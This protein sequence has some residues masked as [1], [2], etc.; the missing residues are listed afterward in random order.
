MRNF[1]NRNKMFLV[2]ALKFLL[3][4]SLFAPLIVSVN[5]L[6]PF[7]FPKAIFFEAL[8]QMAGLVFVALLVVDKNFFPRKNI[9][10]YGLLGWSLTMILSTIFSVDPSLA[11][12][13]KA[14][15]MDGLFWYL[16]LFLFFVMAS[17]V[18]ERDWLRFLSINS[19]AGLITGLYALASKFLP[20]AI[21]FG[22]QIRLAGTFGNPAFLGTYFLAL[23]FLNGILFL[24]YSGFKVAEK[25]DYQGNSRFLFLGAAIFSLILVILSGTR[26]AWIGVASGLVLF[27]GLV[28]IF[29]RGKYFRLGLSVLL[30]LIIIF[31]SLRFLPQVW[32]KISPFFASR[33]Y[34]LWEIPTP[35]LIVWG[36]G[37]NA[38]LEKPILGWGLEN[39]IY[40]FNQHFIPDIHT[41]EMS[42]FDRPHNK[43]IDLL[44]SGGILGLS[45]YL[46]LF[47]V[48]GWQGLKFLWSKTR[49]GNKENGESEFL[50]RS[51]YISLLGAYFVQNLVLFEMPT[52]GIMFFLILCLGYWLLYP[53]Q[54]Q[55]INDQS[56]LVFNKTLP[57]WAFY[58][59]SMLLVSSFIFGVALPKAAS[60]NT[61][62]SA[63]A[64]SPSAIPSEAL[65]QAAGYY[66][67]ARGLNTFLNREVDISIYRRLE[68]YGAVDSM[69]IQTKEF[70]EFVGKI[71][72]NMEEDL[73]SHPR[74]YDMVVG[75]AAAASRSGT[76]VSSSGV[77]G[78]KT[79]AFLKQAVLLAP[80][81]EDAYQHLFLLALKNNLKD[82]AKN[83]A[84]TLV[85][86]NSN[87]AS[88]W[89]YQAEYEARW[90][91]V[92][93]MNQFLQE[94]EK[95]GFNLEQRLGEWELLISSLIL[96]ARHQ[97]AIIQLKGLIMTPNLPP[98]VY[99]R[100]SIFLIREY[101]ILNQP[102]QARQA[103]R[104]LLS[105]LP[106]NYQKQVVQYL[107]EESLWIE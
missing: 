86:L 49:E 13:S 60:S 72:V 46:S 78:S 96:S 75:A 55:A 88:F 97:E 98:D 53:E 71:L 76:D 85:R 90:G 3:Y 54:D 87:I 48:L 22:D 106:E 65:K 21:N 6:F 93:Q 107:K 84:D 37:W 25:K 50:I 26:G 42:I 64:M 4:A 61:A 18:F 30:V 70:Q 32:E 69:V 63:F 59:V 79:Y 28:L 12:W 94:A 103:T 36:I 8:I 11:F 5:S 102:E 91:S 51:L 82:Q 33:I 77:L 23:F 105:D 89:F 41:Y 67:R 62:L 44:N 35:R 20:G 34:G 58:V 57:P 17:V 73:E 80:K 39:F 24:S 29:R 83:H 95:R 66:E 27:A 68:D 92:D 40:A 31:A 74:D 19:V 47:A 81:R 52:S 38:F 56:S 9:L 43:I 2:S 14:E 16:H 1:F 101:A 45:S 99:I 10:F 104:M 100:N 7:V 15:R